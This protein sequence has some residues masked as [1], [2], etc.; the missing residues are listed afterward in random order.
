MRSGTAGFGRST[1]PKAGF[2]NRRTYASL[3]AAT[4][5]CKSLVAEDRRGADA[6]GIHKIL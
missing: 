3:S 2:I 4:T 6:D 1:R 5:P